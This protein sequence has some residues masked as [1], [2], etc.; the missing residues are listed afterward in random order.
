MIKPLITQ[1]NFKSYTILLLISSTIRAIF[2]HRLTVNS[3]SPRII[4]PKQQLISL[5]LKK[6]SQPPPK[7]S[8]QPFVRFLMP[9]RSYSPIKTI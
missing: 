1:V 9:K 6:T 5:N 4:A 2:S 8:I 3:Y 7:M